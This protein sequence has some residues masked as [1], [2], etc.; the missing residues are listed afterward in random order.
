MNSVNAPNVDE[1]L[2]NAVL[3]VAHEEHKYRGWGDLEPALA[4]IWGRMRSPQAPQWEEVSE[5]V[6]L[7]C[8]KRALRKK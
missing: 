6:R 5:R 2:L 4:A 8:Q 1:I 3:G 7:C